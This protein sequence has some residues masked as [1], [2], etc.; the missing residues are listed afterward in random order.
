MNIAG[1]SPLS[2]LK[3]LGRAAGLAVLMLLTSCGFALKGETPL[4]FDTM[5][6]GIPDNTLFG[7]DLRRQLKAASPNT[8]QVER[9]DEAEAILQQTEMRR[10]QREVSLNA[11]GRVEEY[12]LG[13]IFSFRLIDNKG[14]AL[15][16]DTT[17]A[18]YRDMPYDEQIVQ[19]KQTQMETLYKAMQQSIVQRLMRRLTAPDVRVAAERVRAG[20][21]DPDAPVFDPKSAVPQNTTPQPWNSPSIN[22][23]LDPL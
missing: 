4:P 20:K 17:F 16:P 23:Q 15:L 3:W 21:A 11:Q 6:I 10:T 19:A 8:R 5:Y 7:A 1:H 2:S 9:P 14:N 18:V 22:R 12:E 13:V